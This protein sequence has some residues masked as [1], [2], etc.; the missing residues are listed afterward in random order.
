MVARDGAVND[1]LFCE[2]LTQI[3]KICV[4]ERDDGIKLAG[5]LAVDDGVGGVHVGHCEIRCE[6]W[7][8]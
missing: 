8:E 4:E 6:S 5:E 3:K 1:K 7:S 2:L